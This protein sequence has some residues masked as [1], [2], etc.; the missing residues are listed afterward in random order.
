MKSKELIE[1]LNKTRRTP[2]I[3]LT[4]EQVEELIKD[5]KTLE[6]YEDILNEPLKDMRKDL[7]ILRILKNNLYVNTEYTEENDF[8]ISIKELYEEEKYK[9]KEWL[10][11]ET[12]G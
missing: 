11:G 4:P 6:E 10:D 5:L 3:S 2:N 7:I 1:I 9:I 12:D 8:E